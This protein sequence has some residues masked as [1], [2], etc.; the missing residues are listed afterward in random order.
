MFGKRK[1]PRLA[2]MAFEIA[3]AINERAT[4]DL[5][6]LL[7]FTERDALHVPQ[8]TQVNVKIELTTFYLHLVDRRAFEI[9]GPSGRDTLM[10]VLVFAALT[11]YVHEFETENSK[12]LADRFLASYQA[13]GLIFS[14]YP[15]FPEKGQSYANTYIWESAKA[16]SHI[17]CGDANLAPDCLIV[18]AQSVADFMRSDHFRG[19]S[20]PP[21]FRLLHLPTRRNQAN[22]GRCRQRIVRPAARQGDP[23]GQPR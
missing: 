5:A 11:H 3:G 4:S 23:C 18:L 16:I 19:I 13:R 2:D 10:D 8:Q 7:E 9:I 22:L 17:L 15:L 21:T 1:Q 20:W 14:E 6:S 12:K